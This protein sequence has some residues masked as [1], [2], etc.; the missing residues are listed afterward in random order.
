MYHRIQIYKEDGVVKLK[1]YVSSFTEYEHNKLY[2][3]E[4]DLGMHLHL[5]VFL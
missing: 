1:K 5:N 2:T 4:N 3:E